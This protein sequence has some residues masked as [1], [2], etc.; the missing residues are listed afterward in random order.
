MNYP[1]NNNQYFANNK[2]DGFIVNPNGKVESNFITRLC[3]L[4]VG[5]T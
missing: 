5:K 4:V 1:S 3:K 2:N